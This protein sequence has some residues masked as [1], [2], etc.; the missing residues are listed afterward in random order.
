MINNQIIF[1]STL[2]TLSNPATETDIMNGKQAY[3][4]NGEKITGT[5]TIKTNLLSTRGKYDLSSESSMTYTFASIPAQFFGQIFQGHFP[6]C[7][8]GKDGTFYILPL[9]HT[10]T[11]STYTISVNGVSVMVW[12]DYVKPN[13]ELTIHSELTSLNSCVQTVAILNSVVSFL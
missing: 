4:A 11:G 3:N 12:Y 10:W 8:V 9:I 7:V 13:Y 2:P 1:G 5:K 6:I